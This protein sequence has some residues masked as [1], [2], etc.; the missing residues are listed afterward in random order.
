MWGPYILR[1]ASACDAPQNEGGSSSNVIRDLSQDGGL[2]LRLPPY[3]APLPQRD[4]EPAEVEIGHQ[5]DLTT[6][7][8]QP[9]ALLVGQHDGARAAAD[10][11]PR[12]RRAIDAGHIRGTVDVADAA[13]QHRLRSA[14]HEAIVQSARGEGIASAV[15]VQRAAPTRAADDPRSEEH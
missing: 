14:E 3:A 11:K 13:A 10:R 5:A 7:Q 2:R 4:R 9:R 6:G 8:L 1:D 12:A 15:E